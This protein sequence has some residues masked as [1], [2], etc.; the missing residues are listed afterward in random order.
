MPS[1]LLGSQTVLDI[2]KNLD[3]PAERWLRAAGEKRINEDDLCVSAVVPMT[4]M[5]TIDML[6]HD[7]RKERR[8][9][10]AALGAMKR[11][12]E[13]FLGGFMQ[14]ERIIPMDH[15]IAE[16]WGELL[17]MDLV[18]VDEDGA[19]RSVGSAEKVELA[20]ASIGRDGRPFIYVERQQD[21]HLLIPSLV[22][23][24]PFAFV[25]AVEA[26]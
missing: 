25:Q 19:T 4:V 10:L 21:D 6:I 16:R 7:A 11:N 24:C 5:H 20:T 9:N 1:Y 26:R 18:F 23:E 8:G 17:D 22:V 13:R 14:N 15:R 3:L 2:A 12:A